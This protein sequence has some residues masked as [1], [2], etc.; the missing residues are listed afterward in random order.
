M[1]NSVLLKSISFSPLLKEKNIYLAATKRK[2]IYSD[3]KTKN[4][5]FTAREK[6]E[7]NF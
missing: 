6:K 5:I 7:S 4:G 1:L 3:L 2:S